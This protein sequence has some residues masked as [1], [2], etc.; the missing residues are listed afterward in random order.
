MM[1]NS[2][3]KQIIKFL[4]STVLYYSGFLWILIKIKRLLKGNTGLILTYH[5]FLPRESEIRFF[6]QPGMIVTPEI[7]EKQLEFF[8]SK[9]EIWSLD[10]F[11]ENKKANR[12]I[13]KNCLVITIDD[14]WRDN[15]LYAFPILKKHKAPATIFLST[16]FIGSDRLLWFIKA[17][18]ILNSAN[19]T[20]YQLESYLL[21][22]LNAKQRS[23]KMNIVSQEYLGVGGDKADKFIESLKNLKSEIIDSILDAIA[24]D[25][26]IDIKNESDGNLMMNWQEISEMKQGGIDFGSHGCSHRILT[27]ADKNAIRRELG[28]SRQ[29]IKEKL[30]TPPESFSYP[31]GNYDAEIAAMVEQSGYACAVTTHFKQDAI[32]AFSL[33]A[34]PRAGMHDGVSTDPWGKFS[35]AML[36]WYLAKVI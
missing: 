33:Y 6:L 11:V 15:Y 13:P 31:N 16:D 27:T 3:F 7:F 19:I 10:K 12:P 29:I 26:A 8:A 32:G 36:S 23:G 25:F 1:P 18:K 28:D 21:K 24:A 2:K 5:C 14:G 9:F 22:Y 17:K 34:I 35:K 30:G 4:L 20:D